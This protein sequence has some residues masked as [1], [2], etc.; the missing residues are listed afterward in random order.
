MVND[1][2]AASTRRLGSM[3][4][5]GQNRRV[6]GSELT[7]RMLPR[8]RIMYGQEI[9]HRRPGPFLNAA[10]SAVPP[11]IG[12]EMATGREACRNGPFAG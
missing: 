10:E 7:A 12:R 5:E 2:P 11:S 4:G 9:F 6:R 3:R 1:A 8:R